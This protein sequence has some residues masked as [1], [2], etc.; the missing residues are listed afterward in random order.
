M[1]LFYTSSLLLVLT[2]VFIGKC[3]IINTLVLPC[4]GIVAPY[5]WLLIFN[6]YFFPSVVNE[7]LT[8]VV[9]VAG[10]R[11]EK[12]GVSVELVKILVFRIVYCVYFLD[13]KHHRL[14]GFE[15]ALDFE[16]QPPRVEVRIHSRLN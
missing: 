16:G 6:W 7:P 5:F 11:L 4:A 12:Y 8:A 1:P 9:L 10:Q 3:D 13:V 14:L 2:L 15:S